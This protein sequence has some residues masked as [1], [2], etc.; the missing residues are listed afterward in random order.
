VFAVG[1]LVRPL[2]GWLLG[3]YA[4]RRGRRAG[5]TLSI[6]LMCGGSLAIAV[7]PTYP[8]IA[9]AAPLLLTVARLVQGFS[10][11][12]EYGTSAT[13]LSEAAPPGRRGLYASFQYV[14]LIGGLLLASAVLL[15]LQGLLSAQQLD[16]WGWRIA[17]AI[18][19]ACALVALEL[20]RRLP[21]TW[22]VA[23]G[24]AQLKEAGGIAL[25]LQHRREALIVA[26][27]TL[28]G[29]VAF[30]T[31]TT[32]MLTFLVNTAGLT[33]PQATVISTASLLWCMLLQPLFGA[34]SDHVGRRPLLVSFGVLGTL[35]TVP[36]LSTLAH[37][38]SAP[39]AFGLVMAA[40][41]VVAAYTAISPVVKAELFPAEIRALGV[42]LPYSLTVA[43]FG[44]SASYLAL[45]FKSIGHE[46]LYYW[47]VTGCIACSL[48]VYA[49]MR[50]TRRTSRLD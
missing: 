47:Y 5:L 25:L 28:G 9:I 3:R 2:G 42:G 1:F 23:G 21:E 41:A 36:L 15:G 8:T 33:R 29:T 13:Y 18:G 22:A 17:F 50:E 12:G 19:A 35:G 26:G 30:Y 7:T 20:R 4:D 31:C 6:L 32:Y 10:V 11:G 49:G 44:G 40:L 38:R 45:W 39:A 34:L 24:A 46:S 48:A 37:V 27:L 16:A 43:V 14:T